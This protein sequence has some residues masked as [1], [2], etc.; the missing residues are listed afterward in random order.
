MSVIWHDLECGRYQ[1][2]LGFWRELAAKYRGPVLDIGAG[3]GRVTLELARAGHSVTALDSNEELLAE[4]TRRAAGLSVTTVL[5]DA[6]AFALHQHFALCIVP[7][8]T[9]QLLGGRA[10]RLS[11][12]ACARQHL[13]PAGRLAI[14]VA[15]ELDEFEVSG[16]AGAPLPDVC[17]SDGV[18]YSSSPTA[19]RADGEGFLL[20][21]RREVVSAR[22]E[23]T[24]ESDR[25][26]LDALDPQQLETEGIVSGLQP[27]SAEEIPPT[28]EYVG[29]VV[30]M[31]DA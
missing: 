29:S 3:T 28:S 30:V 19:V 12:L 25:I 2:D 10:G 16:G 31:L 14:A 9:V 11:F 17:E 15:D 5:A 22:G 24:A 6:R 26:H 1:E 23:L 7:M 13:V 21:R 20:E 27:R 8:Q 4:L 18:L